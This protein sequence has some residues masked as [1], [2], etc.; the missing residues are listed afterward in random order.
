MDYESMRKFRCH[1]SREATAGVNFT[2]RV[3]RYR[4]D[5][6]DMGPIESGP[7]APG[8]YHIAT[9][10]IETILKQEKPTRN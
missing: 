7:P 10:I 8:C 6:T 4:M 9:I 2:L 5:V 3:E 1:I